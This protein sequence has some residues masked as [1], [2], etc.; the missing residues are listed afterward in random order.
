MAATNYPWNLDSA[1]L[2]R[3]NKQAFLR[4]PT[5]DDIGK[6]IRLEVAKN[7]SIKEYEPPIKEYNP[8]KSSLDISEGENY[9]HCSLTPK[10]K[11]K[12]ENKILDI[13]KIDVLETKAIQLLQDQYEKDHFS[14]SDISKIC[15][16]AFSRAGDDAVNHGLYYTI[17]K[18]DLKEIGLLELEDYFPKSWEKIKADE[19]FDKK[20]KE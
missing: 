18:D 7:A 19:T 12:S 2:R 13:F 9:E 8:N 3:F 11:K 16:D 14:N 5:A 17:K 1:I 10:R 6:L 20:K 15:T 4:L